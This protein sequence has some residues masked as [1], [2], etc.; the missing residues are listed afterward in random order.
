MNKSNEVPKGYEDIERFKSD[1]CKILDNSGGTS[2]FDDA[3][4][5]RSIKD[6]IISGVGVQF[7]GDNALRKNAVYKM[8]YEDIKKLSGNYYD[9]IDRHEAAAIL[10]MIFF[11]VLLN[12]KIL[13]STR[14][15]D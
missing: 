5:I 14:G 7:R 8:L 2:S 1:V 13:W 11:R 3:C 9:V 6:D 12:A 4:V 15:G 10:D